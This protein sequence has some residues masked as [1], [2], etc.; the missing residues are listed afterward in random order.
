[1]TAVKV[2]QAGPFQVRVVPHRE[3]AAQSQKHS[4]A[5]LRALVQ[6]VRGLTSARRTP[7]KSSA[8][9]SVAAA[10]EAYDAAAT[11]RQ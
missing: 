7:W 3:S 6:R 1:M 9:R 10:N 11:G 5:A 4:C 2:G 8:K